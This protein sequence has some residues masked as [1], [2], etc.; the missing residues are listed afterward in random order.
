[1]LRNAR[2]KL[3]ACPQGK[4]TEALCTRATSHAAFSKQGGVL[5]I[6]GIMFFSVA[7][8][9]V[10]ASSL[11]RAAYCH[12]ATSRCHPHAFKVGPVGLEGTHTLAQSARSYIYAKMEKKCSVAAY[13]PS[14]APIQ[15]EWIR[16]RTAAEREDVSSSLCMITRC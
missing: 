9:P 4:K 5:D 3:R 10:Y 11:R 15:G 1:M 16:R 7:T 12:P 2:P 14:G 8:T 13:A 6:T